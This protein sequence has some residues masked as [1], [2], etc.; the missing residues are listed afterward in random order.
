MLVIKQFEIISKEG[1]LRAGI[2][3]SGRAPLKA[4]NNLRQ[5]A[6][7][8]PVLGWNKAQ[9][10]SLSLTATS[11]TAV[12]SWVSTLSGD[13]GMSQCFLL[14]NYQALCPHSTQL[15]SHILDEM[16]RNNYI[17]LQVLHTSPTYTFFLYTVIRAQRRLP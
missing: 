15:F 3:Q 5:R 9:R 16:Q 4:Q 14:T 2:L 17:P 13:G 8:M 6:K 10:N 7:R 11:T 12:P 1:C